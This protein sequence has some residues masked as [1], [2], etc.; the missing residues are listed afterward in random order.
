MGLVELGEQPMELLGGNG[1]R[2]HE[3]DVPHPAGGGE[4]V[5]L[6]GVDGGAGLLVLEGDLVAGQEPRVLED[7]L[8]VLVGPDLGQAVV[9]DD[10]GAGVVAESGGALAPRRCPTKPCSRLWRRVRAASSACARNAACST[11]PQRMR[12]PTRSPCWRLSPRLR[13]EG[14]PPPG[15]APANACAGS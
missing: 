9:V 15:Q 13:C 11:T 3:I 5:H 14:S 6:E 2:R 4:A 8:A 7:P 10:E 12:S 1:R